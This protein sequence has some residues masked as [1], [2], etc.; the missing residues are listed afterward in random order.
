M[1]SLSIAIKPFQG[2]WQSW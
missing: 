1:D 2:V